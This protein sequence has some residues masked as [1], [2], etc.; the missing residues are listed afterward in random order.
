MTYTVNDY[1]GVP[2]TTEIAAQT[3]PANG[4]TGNITFRY[5]SHH[6]PS[7]AQLQST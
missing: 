3:A 2:I 6:L 5:S 7:S 4:T 1:M